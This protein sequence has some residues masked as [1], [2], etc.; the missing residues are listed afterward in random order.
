MWKRKRNV[1]T[2]A[3]RSRKCGMRKELGQTGSRDSAYEA[4]SSLRSGVGDFIQA[5]DSREERSLAMDGSVILCSLLAFALY[6][7]TFTA[8]FAYDDRTPLPL[9]DQVGKVEEFTL[10]SSTATGTRGSGWGC[11]RWHS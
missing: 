2:E 11:L 10:H 6:V 4:R 8:E 5:W 7:N 3:C 1:T 9:G